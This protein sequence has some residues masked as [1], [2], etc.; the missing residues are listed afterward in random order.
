MPTATAIPPR[1][2]GTDGLRAL[3]K[4]LVADGYAPLPRS[5]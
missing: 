1:L 5:Q 4:V 3:F 2:I